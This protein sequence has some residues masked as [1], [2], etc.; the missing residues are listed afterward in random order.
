MMLRWNLKPLTKLDTRH[1]TMSKKSDDEAIT[2]NCDVIVIFLI[3]GKSK[4]IRKLDS[5]RI[6]CKTYISINSNIIS[7]E[8]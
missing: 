5:G 1:T 2:A 3:Y 7:L 4:A 8:N 6:V